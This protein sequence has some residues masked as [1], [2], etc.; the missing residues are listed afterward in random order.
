V[1]GD[2]F[3]A[4]GFELADVV[5]SAAFGADAGVAEIA[6]E[7]GVTGVGVGERVVR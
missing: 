6:A 7:V 1:F 5:A 4:E 3:A 2:D